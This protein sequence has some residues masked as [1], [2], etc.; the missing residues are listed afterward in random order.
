MSAPIAE[1]VS[2]YKEL[3]IG[4]IDDFNRNNGFNLKYTEDEY[5]LLE[6]TKA[7]TAAIEENKQKKPSAIL[8]TNVSLSK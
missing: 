1:D 4:V 8:I 6:E 7:I 3:F 5:K 2:H